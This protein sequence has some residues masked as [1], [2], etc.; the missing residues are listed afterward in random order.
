MGVSLLASRACRAQFSRNISNSVSGTHF[1]YRLSKF[2]G[3]LRSEGLG[4]LIKFSYLIG[5]RTSDLPVCS[6]MPRPLHYLIHFYSNVPHFKKREA[7]YIAVIFVYH[8]P[9]P[10]ALNCLGM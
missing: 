3:L 9:I 8:F 5:S 6:I 10:F 4:E 2:H 1:C 7:Q